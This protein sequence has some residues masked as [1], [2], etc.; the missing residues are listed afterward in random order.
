MR[1]FLTL[2]FLLGLLTSLSAQAKPLFQFTSEATGPAGGDLTAGVRLAVTPKDLT[3]TETFSIPLPDGASVPVTFEEQPRLHPLRD[4]RVYH[5]RTPDARYAHLPH[6]RDVI[7]VVNEAAGTVYLTMST[8]GGEVTVSRSGGEYRFVREAPRGAPDTHGQPA[9]TQKSLTV[10]SSLSPYCQEQD[11]SGRFVMDVLFTF[12]IEA[13]TVQE[14]ILG[15]AVAMAETVN[16]AYVNSMVDNAILRVINVAVRDNHVGVHSPALGTNPVLYAQDMQEVGADMIADF[17]GGN[18]NADNNFGGWASTGGFSSITYISSSG[19][20]R[21]E[22]GHNMGS[23]HCSPSSI[24][25]YAAGLNNGTDRT[26]MCG[27][28]VPYFSN[29]D[30]DLGNGPLGHPDTA[31]NARLNR[32]FAGVK[33]TRARHVVPYDSGDNGDCGTP[34]VA[35][36]YF[37][38]RN[39][40]TGRYLAPTRFGA[41]GNPLILV[42]VADEPQF[43]WE[44]HHT[45]D[46]SAMLQNS[47]TR[48]TVGADGNTAGTELA[49]Q[50]TTAD[51]EQR[52]CVT[53][54]GSGTYLIQFLANGLILRPELATAVADDPVRQDTLT[55]TNLDE[56]ELIASPVDVVPS[57]AIVQLDL[58][59]QDATCVGE[60]SGSVTAV[61]TGG[62]GNYA[63]E[64]EDGSTAATR[65]NLQP[66]EYRVTVTTDFDEYAAVGRVMTKEPL[67]INGFTT[68]TVPGTKGGITVTAVTNANGNLTYAWSD[69]GTGAARTG[70]DA[71]DYTVTV[72]DADGC[73]DSRIFRVERF[74][75][76]TQLYLLQDVATGDY[77]GLSDVANPRRLLEQGGCPSEKFGHTI[78]YRSEFA[79]TF[80]L[81][82]PSNGS[83]YDVDGDNNLYSWFLAGNSNQYFFWEWQDTPSDDL[84]TFRNGA[85]CITASAA[86]PGLSALSMQPCGSG[87][88]IIRLVPVGDCGGAA[89]DACNDGNNST[90]DD[91]V[92]LLCD[93]C[94]QE[95]ECFDV[96]G[97]AP[98][99]DGDVDGD[100]VCVTDDCDD[101]DATYYVGALCDDG[102][103]SNF[104]DAYGDDCLCAGRPESCTETGDALQVVSTEGTA[105]AVSTLSSGGEASVLLDGI[106]D[107]A[108]SNGNVWHSNSSNA[109]VDI[110]LNT[111][112]SVRELRVYPR[113]DPNLARVADLFIFVSDVPFTGPSVA[114][115]R[116][117]AVYEHQVP[118]GIT[119][120]S[121]VIVQPEVVGRYVRIK[122]EG[123]TPINITEVEVRTCPL[124]SA[125]PVSLLEF[126]GRTVGKANRLDWRVARETA[127]SHYT[128]ERALG[129][130]PES[131]QALG[132][133]AGT[134]AEFGSYHFVDEVAPTAAYYRL[135]MNDLDGSYTYGPVVFLERSGGEGFTVIPVPATGSVTLSGLIP[136][137][138]PL[139]I[140]SATGRHVRTLH[141]GTASTLR[142]DIAGWPA[143]VYF[144][145]DGVGTLRRMLVK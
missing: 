24:R 67:I 78:E 6:Y 1:F 120:A 62:N 70:L 105:S 109:F 5:G 39:V 118:S 127:F 102:I 88:Q 23:A 57:A 51:A 91:A 46:G 43:G 129:I 119:D 111:R 36:D 64:W 17:Q 35:E 114:D 13:A 99:G 72:T 140:Y 131:W 28:G 68:P 95:N 58:Q 30:I 92:S 132:D 50:A 31:D 7:L 135:R 84:I 110:D 113:T 124:L 138:G 53:P 103:T 49:L 142:L 20:F 25:P 125:L 75:D 123:S 85:G 21:H 55:G 27:N 52:L 126:T 74:I 81:K 12:S 141:P 48:R 9:F 96:T 34:Q 106:I 73:T 37:I 94:G 104:G 107:G 14:D 130:Q 76:E 116:A 133:V 115:A 42:D 82:N 87:S 29:P 145:K 38:L 93:C 18:S 137:A 45:G 54:T 90:D 80:I 8:A 69:G 98:N 121:P 139:V 134:D 89:G 44:F 77:I 143:G 3:L 63:Y 40:A 79:G 71:G 26:I 112:Q 11:A 10:K 19:I 4:L 15:H 66:G 60:A 136:N 101:N 117:V 47:N 41:L 100:G 56:W 97:A 83:V 86:A 65:S 59:A 2:S 33:A 16:V 128:V 108:F 61:V 22:Y 32:E 144:V 122:R